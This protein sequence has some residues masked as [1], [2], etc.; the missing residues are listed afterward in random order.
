MTHHFLITSQCFFHMQQETS[1]GPKR[2]PMDTDSGHPTTSSHS[3]MLSSPQN[4]GSNTDAQDSLPMIHTVLQQADIDNTSSPEGSSTGPPVT[5]QS[6]ACTF[7]S[8]QSSEV[9]STVDVSSTSTE[10]VAE[11]SS[12]DNLCT[13]STSTAQPFAGSTIPSQSSGSSIAASKISAGVIIT[14]QPCPGSF[15]FL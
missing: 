1:E 2:I 8:S 5:G 14:G 13:G 11:I 15:T 6:S 7:Q 4:S 12:R 9:P 3:Q 10:L